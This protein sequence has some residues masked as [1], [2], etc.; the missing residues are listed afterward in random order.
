M[1]RPTNEDAFCCIQPLAPFADAGLYVVAD[2][3]GGANAGEVASSIAVSVVSREVRGWLQSQV[4]VDREDAW[5]I[6]E[7]PEA[8]AGAVIVA[9]RE[10]Y[11][12]SRADPCRAGMGT[13][14]TAALVLAGQVNMAHVGDSRGFLIRHKEIQQ[15]TVDHSLVAEFVRNG[16]LTED[17]AKVHPQRNVLTRALGTEPLVAVDIWQEPLQSDDVIVLCSDGLTRHLSAEDVGR[18]VAGHKA[19]KDAAA[20]LI[21]LANGRGG[22]DNLTVVVASWR[23]D[24]RAGSRR[25]AA[26]P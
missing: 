13:T 16:G 14:V 19:P 7:A 1:V 4:G 26:R 24:G 22:I 8:L 10:V 25:R 21:N 3:M 18:V 9:N 15:I 11:E 6:D 23:A 17:E 20:A 2:G 12:A 5:L